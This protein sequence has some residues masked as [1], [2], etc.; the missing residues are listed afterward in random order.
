MTLAQLNRTVS[1]TYRMGIQF[2]GANAK[3]RRKHEDQ[4]VEIVRGYQQQLYEKLTPEKVKLAL[5]EVK[6]NPSLSGTKG[7]AILR[8]KLG[9]CT[10]LGEA[11]YLPLLES[12]KGTIVREKKL[13]KAFDLLKDDPSSALEWYLF[14]RSP[15]IE[16]QLQH[17]YRHPHKYITDLLIGARRKFDRYLPEREHFVS[18]LPR[19]SSQEF[20]VG[21]N[22]FHQK[23]T[24]QFEEEKRLSPAQK[25]FLN[26][27]TRLIKYSD[28]LACLFS[29]WLTHWNTPEEISAESEKITPII[30]VKSRWKSFNTFSAEVSEWLLTKG[31]RKT[32][33]YAY[34]SILR[35]ILLTALLPHYNGGKIVVNLLQTDCEKTIIPRTS[36]VGFPFSKKKANYAKKLPLHLLM[37]KRYVVERPG[38]AQEMTKI[39]QQ[40][41]Q[42][43]LGFWP[44][45]KYRQRFFGVI[46]FHKKVLSFIRRGVNIKLLSLV[47]LDAP[48]N[49]LLVSV[50]LSGK[51]QHFLS[52]NKITALS[53]DIRANYTHRFNNSA[54]ALGVDVNRLGEHMLAFSEHVAIPKELLTLVAKY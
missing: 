23:I 9:D 50:T 2:N 44:Y 53:N 15:Y 16:G 10:N 48:A 18:S 35:G 26:K 41:G 34:R 32:V 22:A 31:E 17:Y 11:A 13:Q 19:C 47:A 43:S 24:T 25:G 12:V 36:L 3:E 1:R 27:L 6:Q 20:L 49:K 14:G 7:S 39:V 8:K 38:N 45:R 51:Y 42:L 5:F 21:I 52:E 37:G 28:E 30:P 33:K 46:R 29:E 54:Q 40:T 4:A